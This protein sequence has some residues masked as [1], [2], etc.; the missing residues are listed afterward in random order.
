[1]E[2]YKNIIVTIGLATV[3]IM[4]VILVACIVLDVIDIVKSK[5]R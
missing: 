4:L 2:L 3:S 5:D 1:M